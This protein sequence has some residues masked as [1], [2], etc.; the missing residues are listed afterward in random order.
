MVQSLET[1]LEKLISTGS[2]NSIRMDQLKHF[3]KNLTNF[4]RIETILGYGSIGVVSSI[5]IYF[6]VGFANPHPLLLAL[7]VGFWILY[8]SSIAW[9]LMTIVLPAFSNERSRSG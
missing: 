6:T 5:I 1:I 4:P 2:I 8:S 3:H 7:G 9:V